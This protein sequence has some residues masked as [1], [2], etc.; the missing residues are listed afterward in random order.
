M[1]EVLLGPLGTTNIV[2][3]Q[4]DP[5]S[6]ESTC[7]S[8]VSKL[9]FANGLEYIAS[10]NE[11][12]SAETTRGRVTRYPVLPGG[13][14]DVANSHSLYF[15]MALDNVRRVPGTR[16]FVVATFPDLERLFPALKSPASYKGTVPARALYVRESNDYSHEQVIYNDDGQVLSF[17]TGYLYAQGAGKLLGGSVLYEGLLVCK[18]DPKVIGDA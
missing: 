14:L 5:A 6:L 18:V 10:T 2:H 16:D 4:L 15:G 11:V 13:K 1:M 17:V 8:A 3:C 9:A 7:T 12:I